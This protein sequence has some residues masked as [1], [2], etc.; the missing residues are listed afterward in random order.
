MQ[1]DHMSGFT[2]VTVQITFIFER[3]RKIANAKIYED[4]HDL[5]C[6]TWSEK[7]LNWLAATFLVT[8]DIDNFTSDDSE[9]LWPWPTV[10]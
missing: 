7:Y 8:L 2:V 9:I 1:V 10:G 6:T 4:K 5:Y 3:K